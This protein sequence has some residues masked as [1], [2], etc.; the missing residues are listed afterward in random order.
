MTPICL[1]VVVV[2][3][4][5]LKVPWDG[6]KK[7]HH[8]HQLGDLESKAYFD[9]VVSVLDG[10]DPALVSLEEVPEESVLHLRQ[11]HELALVW[12]KHTEHSF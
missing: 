10:P 8:V 6:K 5:C 7:S 1:L 4:Q 12:N 3:K 9:G 2:V 11:G